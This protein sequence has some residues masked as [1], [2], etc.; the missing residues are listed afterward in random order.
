[1][2]SSKLFIHLSHKSSSIKFKIMRLKAFIICL[3]AQIAT[4]QAQTSTPPA[5]FSAQGN[6]VGKVIDKRNNE[7]LPYASVTIKEDGK[8]ITGSMTKD[9]G[10]FSIGN[11]PLKSLSIEVVFMGYKKYETTIILDN[12]NKSV[13]LK[14]ISL[15]EEA[16]LLNEVSVVKEKSS[17]E[18]KID[19]KVITVG[20][21][22]VSA[23]AT[24]ADI[25]N[26]IPSVSIDQQ[27]NTVSLRGN[28]NVKIFIDGKPSN[29]TAMQALQQ[30]P[31]TSIKQIELITNPSAKYNP[32]GMSGI[33]NIVLNK[34]A[35]LGFNGNVNTG[36][37][38]A[39]TPKVNG[40]LDLN[41]RVNKFNFYTSYSLNHG[42]QRNVG[43]IDWVDYYNVN[44]NISEFTIVNFNK[45]HF[46]KVGVDFYLNDKNTLSFY[47]IQS[48][49]NATGMFKNEMDFSTG[50]LTDRTQVQDAANDQNNHTYNLVYR[51][52]MEKPEKT[53][54]FEINYNNYS[55]TEDSQF[56]DGDNNLLNTNQVT[57]DGNNLIANLD[58]V[59]PVTETAKIEL[60]IE[61]RFDG[62]DNV[63]NIDNSYNS[64]FDYRRNIQSGY[65]NYNKQAGKWSYQLGARLE[66]YNVEANFRKVSETPRQFKDYIFTAYPSAF[67]TYAPSESNSYNFS[68]SRRVDR[69]NLDQ[70]NPIREWSSPTIDQEGNT[71]LKPQFTNSLEVNYTR[72][73]KIGSIT[74]G[75]FFR[76]INDDISQVIVSHPTD[77]S[78]KLLTF[79]NF[80]H[81]TEYGV[82]VSGNVDFKKWWGVNFGM[83]T[84]F[85]NVKGVVEDKDGNLYE[86]DVV[87]IP[88]NARMNHTFKVNKDLRLTWFTMY[89]SGEKGLQFSNKNMWKTDLGARLNVLKG[90]GTL[91]VRYNDIFAQMRARFHSDNPDNVKGQFNWES[92]SV[93][94]NFSYRFGSGKDK[95]LQRKQREKNEAQGGGIF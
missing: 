25:M 10:T 59:N 78:K 41:Y 4:L 73:I 71:N 36:V 93:N 23:G 7:P 87:A 18:Q 65:F 15:E 13:N 16:K 94:V 30:I 42:K 56:H 37:T 50:P 17:V 19:R 48:F 8:V 3:L 60:G 29:L 81:N 92:R 24:A 39:K 80:D 77:A 38:F 66:S 64:D 89:R 31:S 52:K 27:S 68:Y 35:Q 91:S 12:E 82:E 46:G 32:E 49:T 54:D 63:F 5:G 40:G 14:S 11:L 55:N 76:Y 33:I 51:L 22:L 72:K 95:A 88:F 86:D 75:V 69:P 70:V 79:T 21:D 2:H 20:K 44:N 6:V 84:Y 45:N 28:E 58:F 9:N 43:R 61:S 34:N 53:L 74:S 67:F 57:T 47:T 85:K 62:T 83:D 90:K 26:N 1:M